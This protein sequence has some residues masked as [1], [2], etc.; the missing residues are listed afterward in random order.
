MLLTKGHYV[1]LVRDGETVHVPSE[2]AS[3]GESLL[4][5]DTYGLQQVKITSIT[6]MMVPSSDLVAIYTASGKVLVNGGLLASCKSEYDMSEYHLPLLA[7]LY[8][9]VHPGAP[10]TLADLASSLRLTSALKYIAG[11]L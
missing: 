2:N 8:R 11:L 1:F 7:G 6:S 4:F 9:Y 10:Q 3:V 5:Q